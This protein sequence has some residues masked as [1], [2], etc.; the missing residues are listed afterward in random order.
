VKIGQVLHEWQYVD[1][2]TLLPFF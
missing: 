2:T 1:L